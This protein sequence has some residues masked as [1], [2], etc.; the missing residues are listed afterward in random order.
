MLSAVKKVKKTLWMIDAMQNGPT[1]LEAFTKA[2]SSNDRH[3]KNRRPTLCT[4]GSTFLNRI[5][6]VP[7]VL[8]SEKKITYHKS[9]SMHDND[10]STSK[11]S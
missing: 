7:S 8:A 5:F 4:F 3:H 6:F 10:L 9:T 2:H 11:Y 1:I